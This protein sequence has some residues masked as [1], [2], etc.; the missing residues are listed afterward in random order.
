MINNNNNIKLHFITNTDS[1]YL[2]QYEMISSILAQQPSLDVKFSV[3]ENTFVGSKQTSLPF[4]LK[5]AY[6]LDKRLAGCQTKLLEKKSLESLSNNTIYKLSKASLCDESFITRNFVSDKQVQCLI[7]N[8]TE[9]TLPSCLYEVEDTQVLSLFFSKLRK[10]DSLLTGLLEF[11]NNQK[12]VHTGVQLEAATNQDNLV[13]YEAEHSLESASL[14]RTFET[15]LHKTALFLPHVLHKYPHYLNKSVNN[16]AV[17]SIENTRDT[18]LS[19]GEQLKLF[20][21]FT[22]RVAYRLWYRFT[23]GEQWIMMLASNETVNTPNM[24]F[25]TFERIMPPKSE[26]W[27][28]PFLIEHQEK[29]YLFFEVFPFER[30]LGHLSCMEV[31]DDGTFGEVV[32]ILERPYHFSYPNVFEYENQMYMVPETGGY[33]CIQLYKASSFPYKWDF[34]Y[35]LMDGIRAFDS[36]FIEHDGVWW[37]FATVS[38]TEKC[39]TTEELHVFY[40]DSP[41]SQ[42]W[43]PHPANPINTFASSARPAGK[44]FKEEGRLYRPSQDCAGSYGAGINVCEIITLNKEHYEEV[45]L[46][47]RKPDWDKS[48]IGLH[49]LNFDSKYTVIDVILDTG[50]LLK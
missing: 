6:K 23:E 15:I 13:L 34:Q 39:A 41:L 1:I 29:H 48:L 14:C 47:K 42:D 25:E 17:L 24:A 10:L 50:G 2:W 11:T 46:S 19:V 32:K 35:N 43:T 18:D 12:V 5:L 45:I 8:L 16:P 26:F 22:A 31:H 7:I 36:T 4:L 40:A 9:Q 21:K 30:D 38:E 27:A 33:Q 49:T 44:I 37:L 3:L 28:D 20:S